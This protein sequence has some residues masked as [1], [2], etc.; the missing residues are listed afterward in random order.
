[1]RHLTLFSLF[2]KSMQNAISKISISHAALIELQK[3]C[4][5]E[6]TW[7]LEPVG[8]SKLRIFL[9]FK[10]SPFLCVCVGL[11]DIFPV[12]NSVTKDVALGPVMFQSF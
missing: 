4:D 11:S 8:K 12:K 9:C 7:T 3:A 1:M 2:G 10:T 6:V 5:T